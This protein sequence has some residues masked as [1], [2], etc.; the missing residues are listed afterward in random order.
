[1][2]TTLVILLCTFAFATTSLPEQYPG[3]WRTDFNPGIARALSK[4]QVSGCGEF[5]YKTNSQHL[6]EYIV[7]CT[8]DGKIW[9]SY[10]VW[11]GIDKVSGP[12]PP[13]PQLD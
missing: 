4:H 3:P 6:R 12:Y 7:R 5:K 13:D 8:C 11:V 1:M 2:S 10:L 9:W